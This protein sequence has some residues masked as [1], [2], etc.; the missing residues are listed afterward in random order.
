MKEQ[1]VVEKNVGVVFDYEN[2]ALKAAIDY[3][4]TISAIV[5]QSESANSFNISQYTVSKVFHP[6]SYCYDDSDNTHFIE[7]YYCGTTYS[8]AVEEVGRGRLTDYLFIITIEN[9]VS[10]PSEDDEEGKSIW[11]TRHCPTIYLNFRLTADKKNMITTTNEIQFGQEYEGI[12]GIKNEEYWIICDN[13]RKI[14]TEIYMENGEIHRRNGPAVI[15]H[16]NEAITKRE[17]W[18]LGKH[19]TRRVAK[20]QLG[21]RKLSRAFS[22]DDTDGLD[23]F[24]M[25]RD[26]HLYP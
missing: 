9:E 3:I 8:I 21:V 12:S 14:K 19:I 23:D 1:L 18:W 25:I 17:Y 7:H 26:S 24:H 15:R 13:K 5:Q 11:V 20:E 10:E 6:S 22:T 4:D 2:D 16:N